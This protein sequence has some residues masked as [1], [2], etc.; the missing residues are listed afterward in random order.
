LQGKNDI[1]ILCI[2]YFGI[3]DI[4]LLLLSNKGRTLIMKNKNMQDI[5]KRIVVTILIASV[6]IFTLLSVL[7]I[8]DVFEE[9]IAWKSLSTLG[10]IFFASLITLVVIRVIENKDN[11]QIKL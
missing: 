8:W 10:V 4:I 3:F 5:I 2:I 1:R 11:G 6:T 7:A 9:D